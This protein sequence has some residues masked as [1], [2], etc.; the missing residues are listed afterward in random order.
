M[1]DARVITSEAV[2]SSESGVGA[3]ATQRWFA[4]AV[5]ALSAWV[6]IASQADIARSKL[7]V[8]GDEPH[9]LMTVLSIL[10]D[11]DLNVANNYARRDY[12]EIG[13]GSLESQVPAVGDFIPPEKGIGFPALLVPFHML[14][15]VLGD[16]L[17]VLA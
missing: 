15:R 14:G 3:S 6:F 1:D 8:S 2:H 12:L 16:R 10:K 4:Y 11:G 5:L 9:E 13:H 17:A 7:R